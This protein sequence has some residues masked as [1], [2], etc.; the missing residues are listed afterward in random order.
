MAFIPFEDCI[1]TFLAFTG[2]DAVECGYSLCFKS[3]VPVAASVMN[4]LGAGI[5][6]WFDTTMQPLMTAGYTL[7]RVKMR[8]L[9]SEN[10][11]LVDWVGILPLTGTLAGNSLPSN[12]CWCLKKQT[13]FSGRS[14]RGRLYHMGLGE[15]QVSGNYLDAV[16]AADVEDAWNQL[17]ALMDGTADGF[18]LVVPSRVENGVPR[19]VGVATIVTAFVNTDIRIDTQRRRLPD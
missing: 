4:D 3:R 11:F 15:A 10:S 9:T 12:T 16:Y 5:A 6:S 8:D 19:T 1:D 14:Y 18:D 2:P 13:G 17:I 7:T